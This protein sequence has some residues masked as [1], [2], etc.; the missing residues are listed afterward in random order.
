[1]PAVFIE[2]LPLEEIAKNLGIIYILSLATTSKSFH[3]K[4][5]TKEVSYSY[6]IARFYPSDMSFHEMFRYDRMSSEGKMGYALK[7][8]DINV[9]KYLTE[10]YHSISYKSLYPAVVGTN[11]LAIVKH[12]SKQYKDQNILIEAA[13]QGKIEI[14]KYLVKN[15]IKLNSKWCGSY[16]YH[17]SRPFD[18]IMERAMFSAIRNRQI[19]IVEYLFDIQQFDPEFILENAFDAK[20]IQFAVDKGARNYNDGLIE[21]AK[22]ED[23][24]GVKLCLELGANNFSKT[25]RKCWKNDALV[26]LIEQYKN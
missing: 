14:V 18:Q 1:M 16:Y 26:S 13:K 4:I 11:N 8:N 23:Y 21:A 2:D 24:D 17:F 5:L 3:R 12:L 10:R 9:V 25:I 6:A 22:K 7:A 20:I 15:A 19:E